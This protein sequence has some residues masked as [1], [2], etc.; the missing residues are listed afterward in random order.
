[1]QSSSVKDV[2]ASIWLVFY[3]KDES[4]EEKE[5]KDVNVEERQIYKRNSPAHNSGS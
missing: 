5:C 1:M 2:M 3:T 4:I